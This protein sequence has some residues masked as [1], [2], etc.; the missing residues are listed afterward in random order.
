MT[1]MISLYDTSKSETVMLD[2]N[3]AGFEIYRRILWG[4][5]SMVTRGVTHLTQLRDNDLWLEPNEF[6]AFRDECN[7]IMQHSQSIAA[8]IWPREI[9]G[10]EQWTARNLSRRVAE[11]L[12]PDLKTRRITR[13]QSWGA[14]HI[15]EYIHRFLNALEVAETNG[16]VFR[17]D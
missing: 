14:E 7:H 8:E 2:D 3:A 9:T 16:L 6:A 5:D 4:S 1:L 11:W 17:I 13:A 10:I 12:F 15:R